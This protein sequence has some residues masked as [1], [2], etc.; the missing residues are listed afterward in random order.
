MEKHGS[1][2]EACF[3]CPENENS[4]D[5]NIIV[6]REIYSNGRNMCKING[7]M[8]TV[9][10]L[11]EF[12]KNLIDIHGQN[13]NQTLLDTTYHIKYL[14]KYLQKEIYDIESKYKLKYEE[15]KNLKENLKNNYG[16][17]KEKQRRLDLLKYQIKEINTADLKINEDIELEEQRRIMQN[18]ERILINLQEVN[19]NLTNIAIDAINNS[20]R[21]LE[22]IEDL[23][24]KYKEKLTELK[25]LYYEVQEIARDVSDY[26]VDIN[27]EEKDR[28]IVEERLETISNLKRKYGTSSEE[29]LNYA[30]NLRKEIE[31]IENAEEIN[32][33]NR[34]R[35]EKL[36]TE[37]NI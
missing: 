18:S 7:R 9:N 17:E 14:D 37:L 32:N 35:M 29:I 1:F 15:Y 2:V 22:K 5:G 27:F 31:I 28:N 8:C 30:E 21:D 19:N 11:R 6:S 25:S 20:I 10:E 23:D 34:K 3:Y 24:L 13:D 26:T 4:V 33:E 16:D 12:M 36:E